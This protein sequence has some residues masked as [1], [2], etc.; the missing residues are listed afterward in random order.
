MEEMVTHKMQLQIKDFGKLF[1]HAK[2]EDIYLLARQVL[3]P[4]NEHKF[5]K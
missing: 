1:L 2:G 3:I 4:Q 5:S